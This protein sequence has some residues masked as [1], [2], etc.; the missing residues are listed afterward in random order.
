MEGRD[1]FKGKAYRAQAKC[2]LK[3][4]TNQIDHGFCGKLR[5]CFMGGVEMWVSA[6]CT[7]DDRIEKQFLLYLS[8]LWYFI[9][10]CV[11]GAFPERCKNVCN[12]I[13]S[14]YFF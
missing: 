8:L 10:S 14:N 4:V 1:G 2:K 11:L 9:I 12:E 3:I 13:I 7:G 5:L 6:V